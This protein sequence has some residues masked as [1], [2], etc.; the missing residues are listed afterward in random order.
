MIAAREAETADTR[1]VAAASAATSTAGP[2]DVPS[3]L[4]AGA[5]LRESPDR[6]GD[7]T[8]PTAFES[9]L[10]RTAAQI[11]REHKARQAA[12]AAAAAAEATTAAGSRGLARGQP[13]SSSLRHGLPTD[14]GMV[15]KF[16]R[17]PSAPPAAPSDYDDFQHQVGGASMRR[18]GRLD[19]SG[20]HVRIAQRPSSSSSIRDSPPRGVR[21][22]YVRR[23]RLDDDDADSLSDFVQSE[24]HRRADRSGGRRGDSSGRRGADV[25]TTISPDDVAWLS[26]LK[27]MWGGGMGGFPPAPPL[28]NPAAMAAAAASSGMPPSILAASAMSMMNPY[29]YM[30]PTFQPG[31]AMPM[32]ASMYRP[33]VYG[34]AVNASLYSQQPPPSPDLSLSWVGQGRPLTAPAPPGT[35]VPTQPPSQWT[36]GAAGGEQHAPGSSMMEQSLDSS[37]ML[38]FVDRSATSG[39]DA[40]A[41]SPLLHGAWA[42]SSSQH[43]TSSTGSVPGVHSGVPA[44]ASPLSPIAEHPSP[45]RRAPSGS[46]PIAGTNDL[47]TVSPAREAAR[48]LA[49]AGLLPPDRDARSPTTASVVP[50]DMA[51]Q[52]TASP[53]SHPPVA[54]A[55]PPTTGLNGNASVSGQ[56]GLSAQRVASPPQ[57][58]FAGRGDGEPDRAAAVSPGTFSDYRSKRHDLRTPQFMSGVTPVSASAAALTNGGAGTAPGPGAA[59]TA[60]RAAASATPSRAQRTEASSRGASR[61][62]S[63][64][65]RAPGATLAKSTA[66]KLASGSSMSASG[67]DAAATNGGAKANLADVHGQSAQSD[68]AH[69]HNVSTRVASSPDVQKAVEL[70]A[71]AAAVA[72]ALLGAADVSAISAAGSHGPNAS[73]SMPTGDAASTVASSDNVE[74]VKTPPRAAPAVGAVPGGVLAGSVLDGGAPPARGLSARSLD[75]L[76]RQRPATGKARHAA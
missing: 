51:Q 63:P 19:E 53:L 33:P 69:D 75:I 8:A 57:Q 65:G 32:L 26:Q 38:V 64:G 29:L 3:P 74:R 35:Y 60:V 12:E 20:Q 24:G 9:S 70:P 73:V 59:P 76:V 42:R 7:H 72:D 36:V 54:Q 27:A 18:S 31:V 17:P 66:A 11:F 41:G 46:L 5:T 58:G 55:S 4:T 14:A 67:M 25:S 43:M 10:P 28:M 15:T 1:P 68:A 13:S 49:A 47:V 21:D 2:L 39:D 62:G 16:A 50:S 44:G 23:G 37:T 6:K 71:A 48:S 34:A 30:Q 52:L 40:M 22:S 61:H 45:P 56:P